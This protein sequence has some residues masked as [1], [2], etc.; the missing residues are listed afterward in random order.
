MVNGGIKMLRKG[1]LHQI[2]QRCIVFGETQS[3]KD[4]SCYNS[5]FIIRNYEIAINPFYSH[6]IILN[7][8]S[9]YAMKK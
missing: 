4:R 8:L 5:R 3:I 9:L 2:D 1:I 6:F 7:N